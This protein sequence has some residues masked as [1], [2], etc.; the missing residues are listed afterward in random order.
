MANFQ[1]H[2]KPLV[3]WQA[4]TVKAGEKPEKIAASY[5]MSVNELK[6]VNNINTANKFRAGLPLLV[7]VKDGATPNLPDLPATPVTLPKAYKAARSTHANTSSKPV[8]HA[9]KTPA[10]KRTPAKRAQTPIKTTPKP[11]PPAKPAVV[12]SQNRR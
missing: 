12:A 11:K 4:H 3:S 7:P 2:D 10:S 1:N 9:T 8:K 6:Q 5:G